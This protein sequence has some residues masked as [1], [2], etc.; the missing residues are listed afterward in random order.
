[1]LKTIDFVEGMAAPVQARSN[2]RVRT[3]SGGGAERPFIKITA[4]TDR[5]NYIG[6]VITPTSATKLV[7]DVDIEA[8]DPDAGGSL[9]VGDEMF[10]D[11]V[12]DIYY[13]S[14]SVF[15]GS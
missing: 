13:I 1:M 11:I 3:R 15:R 5:N 9:K 8:R 6:D 10:A 4:V 2:R 7:E 12:D 14:P